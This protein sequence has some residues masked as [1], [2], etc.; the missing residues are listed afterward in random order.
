[1]TPERKHNLLVAPVVFLVRLPLLLPF[2][3]LA[4][5]GK[6]AEGAGVWLGRRLP[7]LKQERRHVR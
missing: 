1:M 4:E 6:L 5:V 2:W 7:S 3:L